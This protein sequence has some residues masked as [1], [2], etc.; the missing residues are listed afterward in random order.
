MTKAQGGLREVIDNW[1]DDWKGG[2]RKKEKI[3]PDAEPNKRDQ[4]GHEDED[5]PGE[6]KCHEEGVRVE[7]ISLGRFGAEPGGDNSPAEEP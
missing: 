4:D 7:K 5:I 3:A 6:N 2:D 1:K